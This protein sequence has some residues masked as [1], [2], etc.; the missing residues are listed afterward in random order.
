MLV[1]CIYFVTFGRVKHQSLL[2]ELCELTHC[3][4]CFN[5]FCTC[6]IIP[7]IH[8]DMMLASD[9]APSSGCLTLLMKA[10][11]TIQAVIQFHRT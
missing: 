9:E 8:A 4:C 11:L 6:S 5:Q 7:R 10:K 1:S 2:D 3:R